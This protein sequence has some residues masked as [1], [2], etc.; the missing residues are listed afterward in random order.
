[1]NMF[2]FVKGLNGMVVLEW[3]IRIVVACFLGG[4]V[5]MER[6]KRNKGAG[7][8]THMLV[9]TASALIMITSEF[10]FM[11]Y[12]SFMS[13][14]P[15]RLG[16]QIISGIGFLGA[17]TI[18]KE[19]GNIIGLTTAA[20]L[21][22][23]AAVGISCGCGFYYGGAFCTILI[24]VVLVVLKKIEPRLTKKAAHADHEEASEEHLEEHSQNSGVT[25]HFSSI[26]EAR[27][28]LNK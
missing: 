19:R 6:E 11:S 3:A 16:A 12:S 24:L 25:L 5:G 9:S 28:F 10:M 2:D 14:D 17:G 20:S 27:E 23:V 22:A 1:M 26:E 8:C 4:I 18:I 7:F 13:L 21:W 15:T